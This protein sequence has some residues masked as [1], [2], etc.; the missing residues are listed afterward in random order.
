MDNQVLASKSS[1]KDHLGNDKRLAI[2]FILTLIIVVLIIAVSAFSYLL[3]K[4]SNAPVVSDNS[5]GTDPGLGLYNEFFP[6]SI[7]SL[8]PVATVSGSKSAKPGSP[9]LTPTPAV[10]SMILSADNNLNGFRSSNNGGNNLLEIRAGRNDGLVTRGF[11]SFDITKIP[12]K[13]KIAEATL[14]LYQTKI[15]GN[16]YSSGVQIK[17]DHL[18]YGDRLDAFDFA[19]PALT[20]SFAILSENARLEWKEADVTDRLKDDLANARNYSQFRI[21]FQTENSGG[22]KD[23]DFTYFE[24]V[25]NTLGTGNTPQLVV[26]YF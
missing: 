13:A 8:T 11:V 14:R 1:P 21:H 7:P 22:G 20:S 9:S 25:K 15:I 16:P 26:K 18:T 17:V 12:S 23:G 10:K 4:N 6:E 3:G 24:S 19:L 2:N 5:E